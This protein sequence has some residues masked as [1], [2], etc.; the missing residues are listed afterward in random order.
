M[1][2]LVSILGTKLINLMTIK[3]VEDT[4]YLIV[5]KDTA[6]DQFT[7]KI[8]WS[9]IKAL[10]ESSDSE[11]IVYK[12]T[13]YVADGS[14]DGIFV[15]SPTPVNV[16]LVATSAAIKSV[17]VKAMGAGTVTV[18]SSDSVSDPVNTSGQSKNYYPVAAVSSWEKA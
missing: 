3:V 5:Q 15:D 1:S 14:E 6:G 12:T 9:D 11:K 10:I 2:S 17:V 4:D 13:D 7:S 16:T 8:L 18:L